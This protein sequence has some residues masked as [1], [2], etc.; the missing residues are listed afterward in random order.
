MVAAMLP[1]FGIET[2][3]LLKSLKGK[4]QHLY[5]DAPEESEVMTPELEEN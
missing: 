2:Q 5:E 4:D 3:L 1:M